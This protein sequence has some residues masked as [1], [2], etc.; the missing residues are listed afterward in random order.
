[1]VLHFYNYAALSI[2]VHTFLLKPLGS[3]ENILMSDSPFKL[4]EASLFLKHKRELVYKDELN[5][6]F[7]RQRNDVYSP[8]RGYILIL[9]EKLLKIFMLGPKRWLFS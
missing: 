4:R 8:T 9:R 7:Y 2:R 5:Y 1:M 3:L 6:L